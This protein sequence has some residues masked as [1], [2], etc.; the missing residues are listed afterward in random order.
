[1]WLFI[2]GLLTGIMMSIGIAIDYNN[3]QE[4]RK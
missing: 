2:C 4:N 1:M 3:Y